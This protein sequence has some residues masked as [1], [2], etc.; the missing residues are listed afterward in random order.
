ME[1]AVRLVLPG[2]WRTGHAVKAPTWDHTT[3]VVDDDPEHPVFLAR[4]AGVFAANGVRLEVCGFFKE[5]LPVSTDVGL[6]YLLEDLPGLLW[7]L[8]ARSP[9]PYAIGLWE[10]GIETEFSFSTAEAGDVIEVTCSCSAALELDHNKE[11]LPRRELLRQMTEFVQ[12][13]REA[14]RRYIPEFLGETWNRD[15]FAAAT[16]L[17]NRSSANPAGP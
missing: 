9:I 12:S 16:G 1:F 8:A 2:D 11:R 14:T 5:P 4:A 6:V 15:L 13:Y 7:F 17:G 3:D 10:Q